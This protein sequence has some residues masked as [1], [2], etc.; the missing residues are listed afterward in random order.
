M[1]AI[2]ALLACF[3]F[4]NALSAKKGRNHETQ[5]FVVDMVVPRPIVQLHHCPGTGRLDSAL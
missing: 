2:T 3:V 1:K 4:V 5:D